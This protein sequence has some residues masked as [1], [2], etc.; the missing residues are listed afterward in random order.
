MDIKQQPG[1]NTTE[2]RLTERRSTSLSTIHG[3]LFRNRRRVSRRDGDH[4]DSYVDWYG[5]LPLAATV[6]IILLCFAD[7][8]LTT[9]LISAGAVELNVL[10]DWLIQ[11]NIQ[12]FAVVKMAVTGVALVVLVMHFNFRI[13]RFIAVRYILYALVPVYSLLIYHELSMLASI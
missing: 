2:Q 5:H 9:V 8:F 10:M 12:L 13:Y 3:T 1:G 7:A 4:L 6:S 11:R